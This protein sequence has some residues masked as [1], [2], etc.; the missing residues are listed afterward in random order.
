MYISVHYKNEEYIKQHYYTTRLA[1]IALTVWANLRNPVHHLEHPASYWGY[2]VSKL[3]FP[4]N[5]LGISR[6]MK[7]W[8]RHFN[9]VRGFREGIKNLEAFVSYWL[10]DICW[11]FF[12]FTSSFWFIMNL[13]ILAKLINQIT[14]NLLGISSMLSG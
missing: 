2:P 6:W 14:S 4:S 7:K 8:L 12:L 5:I 10:S 9:H 1:T 3:E 13:L 11:I